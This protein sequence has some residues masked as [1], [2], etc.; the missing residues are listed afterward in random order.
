MGK[1]KFKVVR[2]SGR[3]RRYSVF[4]EGDYEL[5]YPKGSIVRAR[6]ESLGVSVFRT[7]KQAELFQDRYLL[8]E[9]IRV[10]PIGRGKTVKYICT[11]PTEFQL[12]R[13]YSLCG[14]SSVRVSP[15]PSGTIFYP[16]VEVLD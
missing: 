5:Q 6:E 14:S 12:G 8:L 16:E 1:V 10:R 2:I 9:I 3:G 11:E 4:A 15:V 13:F 7:R